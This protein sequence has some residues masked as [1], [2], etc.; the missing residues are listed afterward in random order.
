MDCCIAW[1]SMDCCIAW[2]SMDCC[3]ARG[4]GPSEPC[5]MLMFATLPRSIGRLRSAH[6]Q[7][8]RPIRRRRR[9]YGV[10][11]LPADPE[12]HMHAPRQHREAVDHGMLPDPCHVKST[13]QTRGRNARWR[14]SAG[15]HSAGDR[16]HRGPMWLSIGNDPKVY[17]PQR[18]RFSQQAA[19]GKR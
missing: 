8:P 6:P 18:A 3:I 1:G 9:I 5:P 15:F 17:T 16:Q 10:L 12:L 19:G 11:Q 2:G 13:Y 7:S 4:T 14:P